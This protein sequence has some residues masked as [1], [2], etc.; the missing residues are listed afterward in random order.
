MLAFFSD[1]CPTPFYN[2]SLLS[3]LTACANHTYLSKALY[4][5][6]NIKDGIRLLKIWLHQREL[7]QGLSNLNGFLVTMLVA[8]LLKIKKLNIFMSSYQVFRIVCNYLSKYV[9]ATFH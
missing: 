2:C 4:S 8:Y 9:R 3:D 1:T 5:T 7:D 6:N